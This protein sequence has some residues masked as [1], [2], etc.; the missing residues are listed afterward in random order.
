MACHDPMVEYSTLLRLL[1]QRVQLWPSEG[2]KVESSLDVLN[3]N[4]LNETLNEM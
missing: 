1:V 3:Q 4:L 2:S